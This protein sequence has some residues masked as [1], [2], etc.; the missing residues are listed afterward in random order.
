M[1]GTATTT[2][3]KCDGLIRISK[4]KRYLF[5]H[6]DERKKL[7]IITILPLVEEDQ[8]DSKTIKNPYT[9]VDSA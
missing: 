7:L 9:L 6:N 4:N 8:R 5:K 2:V 1:S 3:T